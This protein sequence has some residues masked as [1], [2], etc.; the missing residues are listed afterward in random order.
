M[1]LRKLS[2][3][4]LIGMLPLAAQTPTATITG[5]VK[6]SS[7]AAIPD[8]RVSVR[9][10][11][12]NITHDTLTSKNGEYTVPLLP[13]GQYDVSVEAPGFKKELQSGMTLQVDQVARLDFTLMVGRA[14]EVVEVISQAPLMTQ[15]DSAEVGQVVDNSKVVEMPLNGRQFY[16]LATLVPGAYPPVQELDT[17]LS[18]GH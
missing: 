13:V 14:T 2:L 7:G 8:G 9:N 17:E 10:T 12:T 11:G 3:F 15:T 1:D 18:R 16:S 5:I 6:D 4:F